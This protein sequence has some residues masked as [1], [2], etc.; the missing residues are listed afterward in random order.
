MNGYG[1]DH[2]GSGEVRS[3]Y[4]VSGDITSGLDS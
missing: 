2:G 1:F 3:L 4:G